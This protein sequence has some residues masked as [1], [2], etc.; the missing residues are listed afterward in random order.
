[1]L[2]RPLAGAAFAVVLLALV[3]APSVSTPA[4]SALEASVSHNAAASSSPATGAD[5]L[6]PDLPEPS[7]SAAA[8]MVTVTEADAVTETPASPV[9]AATAQPEPAAAPPVQI[10]PVRI[11]PAAPAACPANQFCYPRVGIAGTIVPY[12]DCT[13]STDV[14]TAI[15]SLTCVSPTY[16]AAHAYTQFGRIAGWRAG[17][18]VFAYGTRY[19][20]VDAFTQPGCAA[21]ARAIAPLSLQTS[22]TPATCGPILVI[23]GRPG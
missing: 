9:A 11:P 1:M 13:G 3:G 2:R 18:V 19:V 15:R 7:P 14:G 5:M 23:Q 8:R 16:L 6:S 21:P 4:G 20:L 22:L 17:D 12:S 10:A